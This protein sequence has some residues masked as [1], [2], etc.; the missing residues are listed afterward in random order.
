MRVNASSLYSA[1][2]LTLVWLHQPLDTDGKSRSS[3]IQRVSPLLGYL[4]QA[5]R[6]DED[7]FVSTLTSAEIFYVCC[8]PWVWT[9]EVELL[10]LCALQPKNSQ[11]FSLDSWRDGRRCKLVNGKMF[12]KHEKLT[13]SSKLTK[14]EPTE[15]MKLH[16]E[17][18][19][20]DTTTKWEVKSMMDGFSRCGCEMNGFIMNP[21][22]SD[23]FR[24]SR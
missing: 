2:V 23:R 14:K 8:G 18:Y 10:V 21:H 22:F 3:V 4:P 16:P 11:N 17:H 13:T 15:D 5:Y 24:R 6:S 19:Q 7:V 1:P 12:W 20:S 9:G